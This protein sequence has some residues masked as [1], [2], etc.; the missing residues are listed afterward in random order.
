MKLCSF[1]LGRS[2]GY[3]FA[4]FATVEDARN[5]ANY[6]VM[7]GNMFGCQSGGQLRVGDK[8]IKVC[9]ELNSSEKVISFLVS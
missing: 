7:A 4:E 9:L 2:L 3:G 8:K 5:C 6:F 1:L